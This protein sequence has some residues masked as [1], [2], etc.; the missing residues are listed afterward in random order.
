MGIKYKVNSDFFKE[1]SPVMAYC[2]G[3]IY[4]DGSIYCS[5]RGHYIAITSTDESII[6]NFKRWLK[7][8]HIIETKSVYRRGKPRFTLRIGNKEIY[9]DL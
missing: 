8:G 4:A 1:W 5:V 3:F 7:S 9:Y 2:L 6:L